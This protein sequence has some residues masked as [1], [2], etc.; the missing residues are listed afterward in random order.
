MSS[1]TTFVAVRQRESNFELLRIAA[2]G[3]VIAH[4]F[5]IATGK[6]DYYRSAPCGGELPN[7]FLV[8]GVNCFIL[9]SGYFGIN[10]KAR[11][12]FRLIFTI[13]FVAAAET[14]LASIPPVS[15]FFNL[16]YAI[17]RTIPVFGD[18]NWFIP[19]YIGLMLVSP[20][21]NKATSGATH[22]ELAK[23]TAILTA[24]DFYAYLF[25]ITP[26]S[27]TGYNLFH[28]IYLYILGQFLRKTTVKASRH[29]CLA[30]YVIA[31]TA[32]YT[33]SQLI[34]TGFTAFAYNSPQTV[35]A[36]CALFLFFSKLDIQSRTVNRIASAVFCV[37]LFHYSVIHNLKSVH[38]ATGTT[39]V[40]ATV[41]AA[42]TML[43]LSANRIWETLCG[44]AAGT[45][46]A[47]GKR[48][49]K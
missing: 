41:F 46:H 12:F 27:A 34:G 32:A 8:C 33:V 23:W 3:F 35:V 29:T 21:L 47:A 16:R 45:A 1:D 39:A 31:C 17:H 4:H 7:A 42:G 38:S 5:L 48:R 19:S 49:G 22:G 15:G 37:F 9:I 10:L 20:V 36:S 28:F 18:S 6:V 24:L 43:G 11:K 44:L 25:G 40:F 13:L 14:L 26:V 2:M 30:I